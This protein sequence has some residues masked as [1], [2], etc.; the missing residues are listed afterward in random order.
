[1]QGL[2]KVDNGM[3]AVLLKAEYNDEAQVPALVQAL[4]ALKVS[5]DPKS[6]Q[7]GAGEGK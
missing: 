7:G 3:Q 6:A 4:E 2:I 1:M 5:L